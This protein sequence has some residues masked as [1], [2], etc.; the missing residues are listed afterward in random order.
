MT[1]RTTAVR[2]WRGVAIAVGVLVVVIGCGSAQQRYKVLS[3][4]FDGVPDPSASSN[5]LHKVTASGA[6]IYIHQPYAEQKCNSC[7]LNTS[8]IFARAKVRS[9]VCME[10]HAQVQTEHKIMHGPVGANMCITCHAP[11]QSSNQFLLKAP[12]RKVCMDCHT[13]EMISS[14]VPQHL[15][16]KAQ[17]V[18]C[19][20][21]HGGDDRRFLKIAWAPTNAPTSQPAPTE[22]KP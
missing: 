9:N 17:C 2:R 18:D 15:D 19:H 16:K 21:G 4:F 8:D 20:S 3:T 14:K 10:C 22:A 1:P 13:V 7:H 12:S 11:H 5:P 6:R